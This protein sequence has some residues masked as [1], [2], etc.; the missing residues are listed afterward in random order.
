MNEEFEGAQTH[1]DDVLNVFSAEAS[2]AKFALVVA[3]DFE[4]ENIIVE[5]DSLLVIQALNSMKE[6][7]TWQWQS[8]H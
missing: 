4:K 8:H 3:E 2:A 5:G 6:I 1:K 7:E